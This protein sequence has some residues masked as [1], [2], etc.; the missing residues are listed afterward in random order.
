[1]T[2]TMR[3]AVYAGDKRV[4][5][6]DVPR[7]SPGPGEVLVDVSH[8]GVCGTD[9][10]MVTYGWAQPGRIGGHEWSGVVRE[11]GAGVTRW[12]P[13]DRVVGD[14]TW[15]GECAFCRSG[16]PTLCRADGMVTGNMNV[17][18]E[19]FAEVARASERGLYRIPPGL[20]LR[21]ASLAEPLAVAMHGVTRSDVKPGQR[22]LVMG[23]GPIGLLTVAVLRAR[24][25]DDV[26]VSEPSDR[27]REHA[28]AAGATTLTTPDAIPEPPA[29]PTFHVDGAWD[30]VL[31]C[32]GVK[33]AQ[34]QAVGVAGPGG[35]IVLVGAGM[36]R[37]SFDA[38]RVLLN[39]LV[40]TGAYNYDENGIDT[41]LALLASG[42]LPTDA[43][44]EPDDVSL[45]GMQDA[46]EGLAAGT[47][48]SKVL[49]NPSL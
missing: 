11:V 30:V 2:T 18:A 13:G 46:L 38:N 12:Q 29:M 44:I 42:T 40:I 22:V 6:A 37:P 25:V 31:E 14:P 7:P 3:A 20:D 47:I 43:L 26:T 10:H 4:E 15:C 41:A 16:R 9:V 17:G 34:S 23:A 33:A 19:A 8:C 24:G 32:S 5:P 1:M 28:R 35:T 36:G 39:E 49:V 45:A 27:R 21:T 48:P